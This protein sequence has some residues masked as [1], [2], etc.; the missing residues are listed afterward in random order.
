MMDPIDRR[1]ELLSIEL[2]DHEVDFAGDLSDAE[3]LVGIYTDDE[4]PACDGWGRLFERH[5]QDLRLLLLQVFQQRFRAD[6][7][8][9]WIARQLEV[10]DERL[11]TE[12]RGILAD[13]VRR[14]CVCEGEAWEGRL[15]RVTASLGI[16]A[17]ELETASLDVFGARRAL[18]ARLSRFEREVFLE[19]YDRAR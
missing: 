8:L 3:I 14:E 13:L 4:L 11:G 10:L 19:W 18:D 6:Y 7:D 5:P 1:F 9:D 17:G 12:H 2:L 16:D 15:D